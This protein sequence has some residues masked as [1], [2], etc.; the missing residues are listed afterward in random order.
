V[1]SGSQRVVDLMGKGFRVA[2][3]ERLLRDAAA[4]GISLVVNFMVGFPGE[5]ERD[6]AQTLAFVARNRDCIGFVNP[7]PTFTAIG[8]GTTLREHPGEFG[9]VLGAGDHD[10][11]T[12]RGG[13]TL[14]VR[15]R[16]FAAF[17]EHC[18]GIGVPVLE[19]R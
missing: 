1:E 9:V 8:P 7:S 16:R 6:F 10:W 19:R 15:Q 13:N 18:A 5:T 3:A 17:Q 11:T 4:A 14:A 12:R 2:D